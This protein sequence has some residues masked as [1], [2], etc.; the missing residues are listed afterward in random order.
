MMMMLEGGCVLTSHQSGEL[1]ER[2]GGGYLIYEDDGRCLLA[3]QGEELVDQL[4]TL[5]QPL[6]DLQCKSA[7]GFDTILFLQITTC[8]PS[9]ALLFLCPSQLTALFWYLTLRFF[10]ILSPACC[11]M[12]PW[13]CRTAV[14]D[15]SG[16][17]VRVSRTY[18]IRRGNAEECG[19]CLRGHCLH[20]P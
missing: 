1:V 5:S 15:G 12:G 6:R 11:G 7:F 13:I 4:L 2:M 9:L 3:R 20:K 16:G 19:V 10:G 17:V 8:S 18:Q 14:L